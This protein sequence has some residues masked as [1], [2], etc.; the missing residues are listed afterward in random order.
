MRNI[1]TYIERC[2][3]EYPIWIGLTIHNWDLSITHDEVIIKYDDK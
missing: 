1:W 3:Q 2:N